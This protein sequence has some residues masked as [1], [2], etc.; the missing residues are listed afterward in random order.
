MVKT[1]ET[2]HVP[3]LLQESID[4]LNIK[5]DGIYVDVTFGGGGHSREILSR[6]GKNGH[7]YSFDQDADAEKN[8]IADDRFTFV[9]SNFRYLRNWMRY[10]GVETIDGLLA[11]LGVSSHHFDDETRGFSFRFDAPLDMRMN[12]RAGKTAA[13]IVNEY[14]EAKLADVFF[15]YG[16][17]KNSRRIANAIAA[18]RQQKRIETTGDLM[19]A[20]EKLMRTEKEKKDLARL[21]QALRIEV[22]HEMDALRDM[23]NSASQLLKSGGRLSVITYHSL[24]D[25]IVKNV[26]KAGNAE[27]KIEKDFFGRVSSPFRLVNNKVIIPQEDELQNNPRSRSAKLRIAE[28]I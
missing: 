21:F 24:E 7:L 23:L 17:L 27:G 2:Y 9:R 19:A 13:D 11:D 16:E 4:G 12:K 25:R 10:Y 22:N 26:M 3:V 8:I 5:S 14:D 28:R 6:L 18:Y 15:L 20:T 1:A